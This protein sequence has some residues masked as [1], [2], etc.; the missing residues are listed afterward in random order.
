[1]VPLVGENR[2]LVKR[3]LAEMR[4]AQRPGLRALIAASKCEPTTLDESDLGFRLAPRINAAGRLYRADAGVELMLTED[5]DRAEQIAIGR[6]PARSTRPPR[7]RGASCPRS[8]N[9]HRGWWLP[10]RAGTPAWSGS[11]PRGW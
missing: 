3:G 11:S 6:P 2:S 10:A 1:M 7:R 4:L 9:G 8:C 5:E